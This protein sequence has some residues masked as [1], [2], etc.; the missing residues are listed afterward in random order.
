MDKKEKEIVE[1]KTELK[2]LN[3]LSKELEDKIRD[4][5][6]ELERRGVAKF[7]EKGDVIERVE[8][9]EYGNYYGTQWRGIV[10]AKKCEA[11]LFV[12]DMYSDK[13]RK[14]DANDPSIVKKDGHEV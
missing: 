6:T 12:E 14:V 4:V 11:I 7:Y 2:L 3:E 9:D 1:L 13:I 8:E 10:R 5:K